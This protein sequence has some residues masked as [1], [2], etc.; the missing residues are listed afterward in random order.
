MNN[1]PFSLAKNLAKDVGGW[2]SAGAKFV[3]AERAEER[4]NICA[5]CEEYRD[6]R[7]AA[8]GCFMPIKV[9]MEG[10]RCPKNKW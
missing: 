9:K 10:V 4:M 1:N 8:C 6:G 2:V 7:C 3:S 5:G